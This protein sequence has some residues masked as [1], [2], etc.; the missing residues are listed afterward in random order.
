MPGMPPWRA[1]TAGELAVM[2]PIS[3]R[4]QSGMLGFWRTSAASIRIPGSG[5]PDSPM[6]TAF[7]RLISPSTAER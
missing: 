5:R 6:M 1:F 4:S 7:R 2:V 3:L